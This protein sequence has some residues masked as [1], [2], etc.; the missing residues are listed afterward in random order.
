M[1]QV[2][3][4]AD[5]EFQASFER[6]GFSRTPH[7]WD[8]NARTCGTKFPIS[9][10]SVMKK[11]VLRSVVVSLLFA[12]FSVF[13]ARADVKLEQVAREILT[14][15]APTE[16]IE[17]MLKVGTDVKIDAYAPE[18]HVFQ[19]RNQYT[20]LVTFNGNIYVFSL[21]KNRRPYINKIKEGDSSSIQTALIDKNEDDIYRVYDD[22]HHRFS[23]AL[24]KK[25]YIHIFGDMHNGSG[26]V[27]RGSGGS[28]GRGGSGR[29]NSDNPLVKRF[30][31]TFGGQLYWVS[32]RPEDISSFI[33]MG[34]DADRHVP[35][36]S[37][38][39]HYIKTD[40]NGEIY[41]GC[42]QQVKTRK[43]HTPGIMGLGLC[44]YDVNKRKWNA[45]G[46]I[47]KI[48]GTD[49][50]LP[51]ELGESF[52][53]IAWEPHGEKKGETAWYQGMASN[54]KFD[55][56]NRMHIAFNMCADDTYDNPTHIVYAYSED[57]GKSFKRVDGAKIKSL[58]IRATGKEENRGTIVFFKDAAE[59][60]GMK[61]M[62]SLFIGLFWD[63]Y[64]SPAVSYTPIGG[65][66]S[67]YRY[68]DR[69]N[70]KWKTKS[71]DIEVR[72]IRSDHHVL[73]DGSMLQLGVGKICRSNSFNGG[74]RTIYTTGVI[75][76]GIVHCEEKLLRDKNMLRGIAKLKKRMVIVSIDFKKID[77]K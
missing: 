27:P 54:M 58:P 71:F 38:T 53:S 29:F 56:D 74:V 21:D 75:N 16:I 2:V 65:G 3:N 55:K 60:E 70:D 66:K 37:I 9:E 64:L 39:D 24:D 19:A 46:A 52:K 45:L 35:L 26:G 4:R 61:P 59:E 17:K 12:S 34:F 77:A 23:L 62:S 11:C 8:T 69:K 28:R 48:N 32:K 51:N 22:G 6:S 73:G 49:Y 50:G 41:F 10:R 31:G 1:R 67:V 72:K 44:H 47:P 20:P 7:L 18:G 40:N 42:R 43:S 30:H 68:Y 76:S 13:P 36:N 5:A 33:L 15:P 14:P 25:G 57:G 63:K